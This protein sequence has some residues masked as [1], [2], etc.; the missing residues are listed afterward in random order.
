MDLFDV[1][2]EVFA[3]RHVEWP[4]KSRNAFMVNRIMAVRYPVQASALNGMGGDHGNV[5]SYWTT[6]PGLPRGRQPGWVYT[7]VNKKE[8][9][10]KV[11]LD[12]AGAA[13]WMEANEV[14]PTELAEA[15]RTAPSALAEEVK[16]ITKSMG[17]DV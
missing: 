15:M 17:V 7:K 1:I 5:V 2:G 11:K 4:D 8:Q 14:G 16:S 3:G 10:K 9:V 12:P 6:A 13:A